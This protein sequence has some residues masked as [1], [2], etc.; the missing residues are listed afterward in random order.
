MSGKQNSGFFLS[1]MCVLTQMGCKSQAYL[2]ASWGHTQH[3]SLCRVNRWNRE[4]LTP[5]C[6]AFILAVKR[7]MGTVGFN[8][9]REMK[10]Q[11]PKFKLSLDCYING[12]ENAILLS[13]ACF[14]QKEGYFL[15]SHCTT[16]ASICSHALSPTAGQDLQ[17]YVSPF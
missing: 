11:N 15:A 1:Y 6:V 5:I 10:T 2:L 9:L 16:L 17:T 13:S 3:F 7:K 4:H 14:G 12:Q 8:Y